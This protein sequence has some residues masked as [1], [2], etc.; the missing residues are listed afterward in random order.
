MFHINKKYAFVY[1]LPS[2][3]EY[4]SNFLQIGLKITKRVECTLHV[5]PSYLLSYYNHPFLLLGLKTQW[6]PCYWSVATVIRSEGKAL[7][8]KGRVEKFVMRREIF[9]PVCVMRLWC[10]WC[11]Y[12]YCEANTTFCLCGLNYII[13]KTIHYYNNKK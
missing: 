4:N 6:L 7:P 8:C 1:D 13:T 10:W 5:F 3:Q 11:L 12:A 9:L 2:K